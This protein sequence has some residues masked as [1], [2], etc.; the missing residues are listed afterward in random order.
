MYFKKLF[1]IFNYLFVTHYI[2]FRKSLFKRNSRVVYE[3]FKFENNTV[4][5]Y[6]NKTM[7]R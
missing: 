6:K 4:H 3:D 5:N 1:L 7:E 2:F